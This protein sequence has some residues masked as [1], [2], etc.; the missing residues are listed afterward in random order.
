MYYRL[1]NGPIIKVKIDNTNKYSENIEDLCDGFDVVDIE[2]M[3]VHEYSTA[4]FV[5]NNFCDPEKFIVYGMIYVHG[6]PEYCCRMNSDKSFDF[7]EN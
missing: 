1:K 4:D 7:M 6:K 2:D 3:S 5:K